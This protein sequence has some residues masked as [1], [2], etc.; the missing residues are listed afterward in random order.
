MC[1]L[2]R[3]FYEDTDIFLYCFDMGFHL[4]LEK[5]LTFVMDFG[6]ECVN[7]HP[8]PTDASIHYCVYVCPLDTV[9]FALSCIKAMYLEK[10]GML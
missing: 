5:W 3:S 2:T 6:L 10:D 4:S 7:E 8:S 9:D 1:F